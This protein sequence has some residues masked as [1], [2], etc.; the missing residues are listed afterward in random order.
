MTR[1]PLFYNAYILIPT[2][3]AAITCANGI[4]IVFS[5]RPNKRYTKYYT[6]T[7]YLIQSFTNRT[8]S[9]SPAVLSKMLEIAQRG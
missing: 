2:I 7:K 3:L 8:L 5:Q 6:L 9:N 4:P 1:A